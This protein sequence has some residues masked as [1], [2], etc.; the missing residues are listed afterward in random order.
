MKLAI[1]G[2]AVGQRTLCIKAR[3]MGVETI[4]F[5]WAKGAVCKDLFDH[6]Y[7]VSILDVNKI[8]D[9][10]KQEKV[11]G[12]VTNASDLTVDTSSYVAE[13]LGCPCTPYSTVKKIKDKY[14]VRNLTHDVEGLSQV[15]NM[16]YDGSYPDFF[17]CIVKPVSGAGKEGVSI[18]FSKVEFDQAIKYA[19]GE[20][21]P[22]KPILIEEYIEGREIS[23]ESISFHGKHYVIQVTDKD[24]SGA[25]HFVEL[26]HHQPANIDCE[27]RRKINEVVPRILDAIDFANGATHI[28]MKINAKGCLYLIEVN[29]RGG[30]DEISNTL[31]ALSTNVDYVKSMI[32]VALNIFK[33]PEVRNTKFAGIYY[34]C[35]QTGEYVDFFKRIDAEPWL[36]K[37]DI[38]SYELN[39]ATGNRDRNGYFIYCADKKIVLE[40]K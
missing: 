1:I 37:K 31:V 33:A 10:C 8:V 11:D 17:P 3:E 40:G 9:I 26:G 35:K 27:M 4:G 25:P 34:L 24:S 5:A 7:D 19:L 36:L 39:E 6:F 18:A 13:N 29:P 23:V 28:E 30:G 21:S 16:E 15:R 12:V 14:I 20:S 2:A 32:E 38:S 22:K